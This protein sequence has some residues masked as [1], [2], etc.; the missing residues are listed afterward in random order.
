MLTRLLCVLT[1]LVCAGSLYGQS[2]FGSITGTA[3]DKSGA[4]VPNAIIKVKNLDDNSLRSAVSSDQ[5]LFT[6]LNLRAGNYEITAEKPGFGVLKIPQVALE[7]RQQLRVDVSLEIASVGQ[8]M[9]VNDAASTINTENGTIG[10]SKNFQQVTT[11]PLNYRGSGASPLT[12]ILTVPGVQQDAAG[13]YSIGG[14]LPS[15]IEFTA[16]GISTVNVRSSG[17]LGQMFPSSE[18]IQEFK[19]TAV[20][21]NAE[22]AQVGDVT[23]TTK[24]GTNIYHGS[25]YDYHQ[26]RA[27]DAT[28]YGSRVKQA[29]VW[30]TF[31]A[32]FGGPV[33]LPKVYN[34]KDKTFFFFAYEGSRKPGSTAKQFNVPTDAM[35]SGNLNGLP[36]GATVDPATG[37]PFPNNIIP[38]SRLSGVSQ[39]LLNSYYPK[40]NAGGSDLVSNSL[41]LLATPASLTSY[42]IKVDQN[43]GSR[44]QLYGRFTWRELPSVGD[45][46]LLPTDD[47]TE[48]NKN[49]VVSY[50]ASIKPTLINE[51]RFGFSLW[52]RT[53]KFPL[54][55]TKAISD[56]GI[57]GLDVSNHPESGAFPGFDFSDGTGF[58][59]I[60]RGK[61]GPRQSRS[62]QFTDNFSWIKG[63]HTFKFGVDIRKMSYIDVQ[64]FGGSDDFGSFTFTRGSYTGNAFSDLL[65]GVPTNTFFSITGPDLNSPVGHYRFYAQDEWKVTNRFT[66]SYGLRWQLHP[67]FTENFG[68]ITNFDRTTGN[69]IIPNNTL[70]AA[71]GFLT[72]INACPGTNAA[73]ACTKVVSA[74]SAGLGEGLRQA[75]KGNF[76]PRLGFAYRPFGNN[77]TVIR[78]GIGLFTQTVVGP[79]AYAL[80]GIHAADSRTALN[81]FAGGRPAYQFP[82]AISSTFAAAPPGTGE[83][84]VATNIDYRDPQTAQWNVTLEREL[85]KDLSLRVSYIGSNSYRLHNTVDLNQV[86][87]STTAYNPATR[88][89]Q[90]WQRILSRDNVGFANYQALQMEGNRRMANGWFIQ[91]SYVWAKNLSNNGG[92]VPTGFPGESGAT[93]ANRFGVDADRGNVAF[94]RRHRGLISSIY[95]L[96][97]GKGRKFGSGMN[98]AADLV[99]GGWEL[100]TIAMMQTGPYMTPTMSRGSDKSN[101]NVVGRAVNVRPDGIR[102]GNG[103]TPGSIWDIGAFAVPAAGV[104]RFGTAGVG[105]LVGPG[106]VA[107]AAGLAK[108]FQITERVRVRLES[109]FTNLPNHPNFREPATNITTPT[110][111]GSVRQVQSSENSGNRTGQVALRIQF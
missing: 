31:G 99:V 92:P 79:L 16:D 68:N 66:L 10:D 76:A 82:Q 84:I 70:K 36:G 75:Y 94:T 101:T 19:V 96:P 23:I 57:V 24:S 52:N 78:G 64:T 41:A 95:A 108:N 18:L 3:T 30:N 110:T 51:F 100:S 12:A 87:P 111:F 107:V 5:G 74:G 25:A 2:T 49:M 65:L 90:N 81:S 38:S 106:T 53:V 39:K 58:T 48:L 27:L 77:K 104:G 7:A 62:W 29:K 42:D 50:N 55:G 93:V 13:N 1:L 32:T 9:V 45:N 14:G 11:L 102:D 103:D 105:T 33:I 97:I 43:I 6:L 91:S 109:T 88:P 54:N 60:G 71:P 17:A 37:A 8:V 28:T 85:P 61:D 67:P 21:N 26:N 89:F 47:I 15:M 56:L 86:A 80:T 98:K 34:G 44:Q 35:R 40:V 83:F 73:V 63:A 69:V 20:N 72:S 46:N 4:V 22:F 59:T